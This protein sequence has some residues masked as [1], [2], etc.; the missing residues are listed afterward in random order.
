M[1]V[2]SFELSV[3]LICAPWTPGLLEERVKFKDPG[4]IDCL[5]LARSKDIIQKLSLIIDVLLVIVLPQAS[6]PEA[7]DDPK[8]K[9]WFSSSNIIVRYWPNKVLVGE[10]NGTAL[11]YK[12]LPLPNL[13]QYA[14][15]NWTCWSTDDVL[16]TER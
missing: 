4:N 16:Y 15:S 7:A 5:Y 11:L 14:I 9:S 3:K 2:I 12:A 8:I 6:I 10:F 1:L 13:S